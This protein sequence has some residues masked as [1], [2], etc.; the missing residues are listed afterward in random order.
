MQIFGGI[1]VKDGASK[2][3]VTPDFSA[4]KD[5]QTRL[6]LASGEFE[7]RYKYSPSR[8]DIVIDNRTDGKAELVVC[9]E[10][11]GRNVERRA[12]TLNKGKN[13]FTI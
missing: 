3:T 1:E 11:I 2:I 5:F 9:P 6:R 12:I 8:I 10:L 7:V 4:V 13:K